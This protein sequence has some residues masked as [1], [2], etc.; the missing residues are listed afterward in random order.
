MSEPI[1]PNATPLPDDSEATLNEPSGDDVLFSGTYSSIPGPDEPFIGPML[2]ESIPAQEKPPS[3]TGPTLGANRIDSMDVL[4]GVA[5]MGILVMNIQSFSMPDLA[6]HYPTMYGDLTGGNYSVWYWSHVL[7]EFKFITIFSM[8]FGAGIMLMRDH[9]IESGRWAVGLHYRRMFFL[10]LFGLAHGYLVWFGD[11]LYAYAICGMLLYVFFWAP[12]WLLIGL[13]VVSVF[14]A[15]ETTD[16][17]SGLQMQYLSEEM[18]YRLL[19]QWNPEPMRIKEEIAIYQGSYATQMEHRPYEMLRI[20]RSFVPYIAFRVGG[21]MLIGMGL[22]RLRFFSAKLPLWIYVSVAT[23]AGA[24]GLYLVTEGVRYNE[25]HEWN[26]RDLQTWGRL[27]NY[28]GSIPVALAWVAGIMIICKASFLH[29]FTR[30]FAAVGRMAFTNY[31][32]HTAICTIIFYGHGFGLFSELERTE[33]FEVVVAIWVFQLIASPIWLSMFRFGPAEWL[34]RTL[35][36]MKWQPM[37]VQDQTA[38]QQRA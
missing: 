22:Y 18:H 38:T 33:Q 37:L 13:G 9:R 30:P 34:W 36:Y 23:L 12:S 27:F 16:Y 15:N 31:L 28:W 11:I 14:I 24:I 10:L 6:Y 17:V 8:L 29:W 21:T 5:V 20:H 26:F 2:P 7:A 32:M 4:R 1:D 19:E 3:S 35:S 25:A